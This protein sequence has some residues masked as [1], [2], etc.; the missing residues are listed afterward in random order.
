MRVK[1]ETGYFRAKPKSGI[2]VPELE[3]G[4]ENPTLARPIRAA[5]VTVVEITANGAGGGQGGRGG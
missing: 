1:T 4:S 2:P 5:G 3:V